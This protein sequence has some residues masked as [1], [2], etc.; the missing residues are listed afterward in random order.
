MTF[1]PENFFLKRF[2]F[3][4]SLLAFFLT[5]P[6]KEAA[7][8]DF[9]DCKNIRSSLF[10]I[11]ANALFF[12]APKLLSRRSFVDYSLAKLFGESR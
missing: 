8:S 6:T 12:H 9:F 2:C 7:L 5:T 3:F 4:R 1:L 10:L 11:I